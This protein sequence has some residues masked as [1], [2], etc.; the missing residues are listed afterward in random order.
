M[1]C[2]FNGMLVVALVFVLAGCGVDSG[3]V[4]NAWRDGEWRDDRS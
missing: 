1:K 4:D 3:P 2:L